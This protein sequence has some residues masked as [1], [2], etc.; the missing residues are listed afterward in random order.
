MDWAVM[1]CSYCI[2]NFDGQDFYFFSSWC[3]CFLVDTVFWDL[4]LYKWNELSWILRP[5]WYH[6]LSNNF[7][8]LNTFTHFFTHFFTYTYFKKLQ[9]SHLK[10][11]YQTGPKNLELV[12]LVLFQAW[13]KFKLITKLDYMS[14]FGSFFFF[15]GW[16]N[17]SLFT[18]YLINL[19]FSHI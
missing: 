18:G 4:E 14:K 1:Q 7:H 5:V 13:A 17:S 3:I 6:S 10:L 19:L 12:Y 16:I 2:L 11:W 8:I 15:F 9:K